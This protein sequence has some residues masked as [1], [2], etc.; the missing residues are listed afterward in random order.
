LL[1]GDA[2]N[3]LV[4]AGICL[5]LG[6]VACLFISKDVEPKFQESID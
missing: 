6:A 3:A 2:R 5:I 1:G 4:L